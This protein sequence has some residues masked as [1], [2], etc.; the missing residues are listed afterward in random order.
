[1]LPV[2]SQQSLDQSLAFENLFVTQISHINKFSAAIMGPTQTVETTPGP[3]K[4]PPSP[5]ITFG[6]LQALLSENGKVDKL[7]DRLLVREPTQTV[8]TTPAPSNAQPSFP[9]VTFAQLQALLAKNA[10]VDK[11]LDR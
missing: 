9:N 8:I 10:E 6:Q 1:M 3:S 5:D 7:L 2:D 11:L 4:A